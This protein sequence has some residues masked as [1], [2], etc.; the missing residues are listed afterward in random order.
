MRPAVVAYRLLQ[1]TNTTYEHT[2]ELPP[3]HRDEDRNPLRVLCH[4]VTHPSRGL[5]PTCREP[6]NLPGRP[7]NRFP[8]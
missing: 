2:H 7:R 1:L 3:S 8:P 5:R 6:R 4:V